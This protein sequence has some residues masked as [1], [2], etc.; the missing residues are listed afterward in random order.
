ML[1][2]KK[3]RFLI[4]EKGKKIGVLLDLQTY[5]KL[6]EAYEDLEDIRDF[7]EA[8]KKT[9]KSVTLEEYLRKR[10]VRKDAYRN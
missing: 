4:N 5:E 6:L 8:K 3:L 10:K 1:A 7:Y 2:N 9:G